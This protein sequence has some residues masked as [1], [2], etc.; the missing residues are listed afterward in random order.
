[1]EVNY[2][3]IDKLKPHPKN[4][5]FFKQMDGE[6][7][8]RFLKDIKINGIRDPL[9]ITKDGT[10][11]GGEQRWRASNEL[12]LDEVPVVYHDVNEDDAL[13][14]LLMDNLN[15]RHLSSIEKAKIAQA[16][17]DQWEIKN[18]NNEH[19]NKSGKSVDDIAEVIGES[20]RTTQRLL[21]LNELIPQFQELVASG[22]LKQTSAEALAHLS[23]DE[24]EALYSS[25]G[26]SIGQKTVQETKDLRKAVEQQ[27]PIEPD[28]EEP[29][30]IKNRVNLAIEELKKEYEKKLEEEKV[31]T[32]SAMTMVSRLEAELEAKSSGNIDND[33]EIEQLNNE[34]GHLRRQL[35]ESQEKAW[36]AEIQKEEL[37][38]NE[39]KKDDKEN[40]RLRLSMW[41]QVNKL[42]EDL[43]SISSESPEIRA[44]INLISK[45]LSQYLEEIGK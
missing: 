25:L 39:S 43:T 20:K 27:R 1:M 5:E 10:I 4:I 45:R 35:N 37:I 17:K 29:E 38:K 26:E 33:E 32:E 21:K 30:D 34:I 3:K 22:K 16:L 24:Q 42:V 6:D 14:L 2:V 31:K 44:E 12:G 18:G 13:T 11:I 41:K 23:K 8:D 36:L 40:D 19:N 28:S 15:R 9:K 7:W